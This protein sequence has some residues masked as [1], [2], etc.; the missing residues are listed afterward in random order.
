[1]LNKIQRGYILSF[2]ILNVTLWNSIVIFNIHIIVLFATLAFLDANRRSTKL[3]DLVRDE[4]GDG[5]KGGGSFREEPEHQAR[6][7]QEA[8]RAHQGREGEGRGK[9]RTRRRSSTTSRTCR[10]S[11]RFRERSEGRSP[12]RQ[13]KTTASPRSSTRRWLPA[14]RVSSRSRKW[15][16]ELAGNQLRG[17]EA[18][19]TEIS[20]TPNTWP[21]H[22]APRRC[23][24]K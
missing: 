8:A 6:L 14:R 18:E 17:V 2:L 15:L 1:M 13:L 9:T 12:R 11:R 22:H 24:R 7:W 16:P 4:Q 23:S 10:P 5:G 20:A 3:E 21:S 19:W